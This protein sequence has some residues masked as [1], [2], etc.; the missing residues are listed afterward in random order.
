MPQRIG[1]PTLRPPTSYS[2][3]DSDGGG[4]V[5]TAPSFLLSQVLFSKLAKASPRVDSV[6]SQWAEGIDRGPSDMQPADGHGGN[7]SFPLAAV[8]STPSDDEPRYCL[9]NSVDVCPDMP[10][11]GRPRHRSDAGLSSQTGLS[12]SAPTQDRLRISVPSGLQAT[13]AIQS[14]DAAVWTG[15]GIQATMSPADGGPIRKASLSQI[16]AVPG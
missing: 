8:G 14:A 10:A 12:R 6:I 1:Q 4:V 11:F 7:L 5:T 9:L 15:A 3:P 2:R 13:R 16:W